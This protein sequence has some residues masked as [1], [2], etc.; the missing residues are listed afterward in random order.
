MKMSHKLGNEIAHTLAQIGMLQQEHEHLLARLD[1]V[2]RNPT[3][4]VQD[5]Q[6][7]KDAVEAKSA[8]LAR[9]RSRLKRLRA[10]AD[11]ILRG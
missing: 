9:E 10:R 4:F 8:E 7:A 1:S 6:R 11:R 3:T 5:V 2:A